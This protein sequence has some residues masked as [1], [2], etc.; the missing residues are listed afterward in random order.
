MRRYDHEFCFRHIQFEVPLR[1]LSKDI[2]Q[3]TVY[4]SLNLRKELRLGLKFRSHQHSNE[5]IVINY[6]LI[7]FRQ[8]IAQNP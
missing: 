2:E 6:G 3:T 5:V 7:F 4:M 8:D 1:Y